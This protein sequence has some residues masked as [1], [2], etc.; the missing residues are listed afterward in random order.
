MSFLCAHEAQRQPG[1]LQEM[2]TAYTKLKWLIRN[3]W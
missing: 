2:L 3:I 1:N